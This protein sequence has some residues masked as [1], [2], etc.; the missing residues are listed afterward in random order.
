MARP[1]PAQLPDIDKLPAHASMPDPLVKLDGSKV[2]DKNDWHKKRRPELTELF[3][4]YMYGHAPGSVPVKA[5]VERIDKEALG[6]KATLKEITLTLGAGKDA[7]RIHLLLI[8]PNKRTGPA[9]V[10]VGLNFRGNHTVLADPKIALPTAWVPKDA[11]SDGN[12]ASDKGR[13]SQKAVW[14][15]ADIIERGFALATVYCGDIDPDR[16]D[17]REGVQP[18]ID[19]SGKYDWGTIAAWAWGISR[20]IDYLATDTAIDITR[21]IV[22]GHSRLGKTALLAGALDPRIAVV[23][24][25]QAGCGGTAPSRGTV[26]ETV[27]QINDRFPHWFNANFKKFNKEVDKLPFDQNGLVALC[28]P[29]PVL[30]TNAIKDQ[31]ANPSGQFEVLKAADPVYRFLGLDGLA[32]KKEPA[33]G[34][35]PVMSRLGYWIRE[36]GHAM[37]RADWMVF[38]D[39]AERWTKAK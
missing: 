38:L 34:E 6:G 4:H 27:K 18:K 39:Y 26:G 37:T 31:W 24:P 11:I 14:N 33:V 13:G 35:P 23:M 22:V 29:R 30:F 21:V 15:V 20:V 9:P 12:K 7:P 36:G 16:D 1:S 5:K 19:P 28:A 10:F 32:A 17:K 8:V 25:H 2:A 3:E